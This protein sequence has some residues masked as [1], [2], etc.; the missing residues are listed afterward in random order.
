MPSGASRK[1]YE[2]AEMELQGGAVPPW[3]EMNA[4]SYHA[5]HVTIKEAAP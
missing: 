5:E 4:R 1:K 3:K 2:L